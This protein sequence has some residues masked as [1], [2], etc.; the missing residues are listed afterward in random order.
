MVANNHYL[1]SGTNQV[2]FLEFVL[3]VSNY[4]V[5]F[6]AL[7][8]P[9]AAQAAVLGYTIPSG[10]TWTFPVTQVTPQITILSTNNFRTVIGFN[11]GTYPAAPSASNF[12][13]ISDIAPQVSP[14]TSLIVTCTLIENDIADPNELIYCFPVPDVPFGTLITPVIPEF[15][16]IQAKVGYFST[17][18]VEIRDQ[19][20]NN[21]QINDPQIVILLGIRNTKKEYDSK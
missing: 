4:A 15:S 17:V 21:V 20:F 5:Q 9:T 11:P 18:S 10:A 1:E 16:W 2:F 6:N 13:K 8:V 14:I 12:S 19:N 3:N 7:T